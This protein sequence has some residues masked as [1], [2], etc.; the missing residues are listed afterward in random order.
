MASPNQ[1][2]KGI[3]I[4]HNN[5]PWVVTEFQHINPGKGSAFVRTRIKNIKDGRTLEQTYKVSETIDIVDVEH[6]T[7]Q[8]LYR[9]ESGYH[10][11][12]PDTYDQFSM[13]EASVGEQGKYLQEG[14]KVVVSFYEGGPIALQLPKKM[15]FTV[16]E[17][18]PAV[19]GDTASGNVT[20]EAKTDAGFTVRVPIFI[21]RGEKVVINTETGEYVERS[22]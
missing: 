15:T 2:K 5:D 16:A 7:A 14:M 9:D 18:M 21:E 17:T 11:M 6:K 19:K 10:F 20:K 22:K 13:D 4:L 8:Y 12:D 3:V 1:I